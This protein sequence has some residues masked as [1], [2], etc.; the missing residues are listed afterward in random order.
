MIESVSRYMLKTARGFIIEHKMVFQMAIVAF[1]KVLPEPTLENTGWGNTPIL[2]RIRDKFAH[3]HQNDGK[4]ALM[5]AAWKIFI[6]EME[7]D[8]YYRSLFQWVLEEIVESIMDGEWR[9]RNFAETP[10]Q[11]FWAEPRPYGDYNGRKFKELIRAGDQ[12][13]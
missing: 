5:L 11:R 2:L 12:N 4:K 9:P 6:N 13:V 10:P 7:H 3:Y 1:A 8:P